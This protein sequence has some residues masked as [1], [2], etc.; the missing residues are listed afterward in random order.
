MKQLLSLPIVCLIAILS[1][2]QVNQRNISDYQRSRVLETFEGKT[3]GKIERNESYAIS[4]IQPSITTQLDK[5]VKQQLDSSIQKSAASPYLYYRKIYKYDGHGNIVRERTDQTLSNLKIHSD[6][7]SEYIYD[8]FGNSTQIITYKWDE[9]L[10]QYVGSQRV[11][12]IIDS[13]GYITHDIGYNWNVTISQW[14]ASYKHEYQLNSD[15]KDTL[16]IGYVWDVEAGKWV[17]N[18]KTEKTYDSKGKPTFVFWYQWDKEINQWINSS[19]E[20]SLYDAQGNTI[21]DTYYRWNLDYNKWDYD[22]RL[23]YSFNDMGKLTK[24]IGYIINNYGTLRILDK[25]DYTYGLDGKTVE[26]IVSYDP[27]GFGRLETSIKFEEEY[28]EYGYCIHRKK[29]RIIEPDLWEFEDYVDYYYSAIVNSAISNPTTDELKAFPNPAT[30]FIA[31][32]LSDAA[33]PAMIE[34]YDMQG[35][36]IISQILASDKRLD[37]ARLKSGMYMYKISQNKKIFQGKVSVK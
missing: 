6:I 17:N 25:W 23:E 21:M 4:K 28:D 16:N 9:S 14:V 7:K 35:K 19:K 34:L 8:L 30:E 1:V 2:G 27:L 13:K 18:S 36:K 33:Q 12:K 10:N 29:Y 32:N 11:D 26:I 22:M 20:E 24:K 3:S 37:V 15:G 5:E 31:F